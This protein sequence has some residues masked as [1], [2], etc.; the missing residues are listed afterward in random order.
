M[1]VAGSSLTTTAFRCRLLVHLECLQCVASPVVPSIGTS[2]CGTCRTAPVQRVWE[3]HAGSVRALAQAARGSNSLFSCSTDCTVKVW[4]TSTAA[5]TGVLTGHTSVVTSVVALPGTGRIAS[6]SWDNTIRLWELQAGS[7]SHTISHER[8]VT[9]VAAVNRDIIASTDCNTVQ[10]WDTQAAAGVRSLAGHTNL[11]SSVAC[12]DEDACVLA[13][14]SCDHTVRVW[15]AEAGVCTTTLQGHS[16]SVWAIAASCGLIASGSDD[17]THRVWDPRLDSAVAV[18]PQPEP[19]H[20]VQAFGG[21]SIVCGCRGGKIR[22]WDLPSRSLTV[23][24]LEGHT[25]VVS[26]VAMLY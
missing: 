24:P 22:V 12:V 17:N 11:V 13:S 18:L 10:L 23:A 15:D 7:C 16:E 6:G 25:N 20:S 9:D 26:A 4:D 2:S 21:T 19:V 1:R 5:C 3:G 8:P 14:G